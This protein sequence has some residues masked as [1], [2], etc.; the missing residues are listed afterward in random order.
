[1]VLTTLVDVRGSHIRI[2][3]IFEVKIV[4]Y[5]F[6]RPFLIR[7]NKGSFR[8]VCLFMEQALDL[9]SSSLVGFVGVR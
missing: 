4:K 3:V 7:R 2:D 1:M 5:K 8:H 9:V 6:F